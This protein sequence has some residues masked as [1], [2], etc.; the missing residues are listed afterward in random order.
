MKCLTFHALFSQVTGAGVSEGGAGV[1]GSADEADF[2]AAA[3]CSGAARTLTN[4]L[5]RSSSD[6]VAWE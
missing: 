2:A 3:I 5:L 4:S 6:S 1:V